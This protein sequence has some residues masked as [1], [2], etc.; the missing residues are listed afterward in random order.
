[1]CVCVCVCVHVYL[2]TLAVV[3]HGLEN[4]AGLPHQYFSSLCTGLR[5]FS[6]AV[7]ISCV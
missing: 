1:M 5:R 7:V 4:I 6:T 2:H 3:D